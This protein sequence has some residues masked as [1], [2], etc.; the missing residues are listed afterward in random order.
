MRWMFLTLALVSCVPADASPPGHRLAVIQQAD[1]VGWILRIDSVSIDR[2]GRPAVLYRWWLHDVTDSLAGSPIVARDSTTTRRDT[3]WEHYQP[4]DTL[5]RVG[6]VA[7]VDDRGIEGAPSLTNVAR[8]IAVDTIGPSRPGA[9]LDPPVVGVRPTY[10]CTALPCQFTVGPAGA[11]LVYQ[12]ATVHSRRQEL[13]YGR[14]TR[15]L[16]RALRLVR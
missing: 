14:A 13:K 5:L 10:T 3:L 8:F 12:P 7:G 16:R 1:S 6:R 9:T 4:G 11:T 15:G 2:R